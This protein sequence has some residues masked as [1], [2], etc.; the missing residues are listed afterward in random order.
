MCR[1]DQVL[2]VR[3]FSTNVTSLR[4]ISQ[5]SCDH[6]PVLFL[7][8]NLTT[9]KSLLIKATSPG[10]PGNTHVTVSP[11]IGKNYQHYQNLLF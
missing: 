5:V 2:T 11:T 1:M 9:A 7:G 6:V 8:N 10:A 3:S 4:F